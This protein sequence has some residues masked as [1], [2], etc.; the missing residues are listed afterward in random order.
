MKYFL[1]KYDSPLT[2]R[3]EI[4]SRLTSLPID[5]GIVPAEQVLPSS[6]VVVNGSSVGIT[7][8]QHLLVMHHAEQE[9]TPPILAAPT[10]TAAMAASCATLV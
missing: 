7:M 8:L 6:V 4:D 3:L 9:L 2:W 10:G 1:Q 5:E